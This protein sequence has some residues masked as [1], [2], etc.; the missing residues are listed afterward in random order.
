MQCLLLFFAFGGRRRKAQAYKFVCGGGKQRAIVTGLLYINPDL[1]L[2]GGALHCPIL[3][4][5]G[6][7]PENDLCYCMFQEMA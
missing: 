7:C 1:Y 4:S 6:E 3:E 2:K 5:G